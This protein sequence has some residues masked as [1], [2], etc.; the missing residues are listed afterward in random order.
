MILHQ[1]PKAI[2]STR[3][4]RIVLAGVAAIGM[5][6][7]AGADMAS[8]AYRPVFRAPVYRPAPVY[9]APVYSMPV[10]RPAPRPFIAPVTRPM[11]RPFVASVIR[12][13]ARPI[14]QA[15]Y[16]APTPRLTQP[17]VRPFASQAPTV[18][19]NSM[20]RFGAAPT[21]APGPVPPLAVSRPNPAPAPVP[22]AVTVPSRVQTVAPTVSAA[23][24]PA[25]VPVAK[26]SQPL[27]PSAPPVVKAVQFPVPIYATTNAQSTPPV[28]KGSS[29]VNNIMNGAVKAA[30]T[31]PGKIT[32]DSINAMIGG[33]VPGSTAIK[34]LKLANTTVSVVSAAQTGGGFGAA[35]EI[36]KQVIKYGATAAGQA[37]GAQA[38][39]AVG[40]PAGFVTMTGAIAGAAVGGALAAG[41]AVASY[42][43][44]QHYIAPKVAPWLGDKIFNAAPGLFT[45]ASQANVN[46]LAAANS[47][48][49]GPLT[50]E[51][52]TQSVLR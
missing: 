8:A 38:A 35:N 15:P 45:P 11:P 51:E 25:T 17:A 10:Y 31:T 41:T 36:T 16:R 34:G 12:P 39:T 23:T 52:F 47:T 29:P 7:V 13:A 28:A 46:I 30:Q 33:A 19:S 9:R 44:G 3:I 37:I 14:I 27:T 21:A 50:A 26:A 49:A 5:V 1:K 24:S 48:H 22:A 43:I 6:F 32:V 4:N 20:G 42:E 18:S 2:G 40:M